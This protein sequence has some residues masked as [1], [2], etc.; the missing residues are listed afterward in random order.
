VN[1]V[2]TGFSG[3][4]KTAVGK[5]LAAA[6]GRSFIDVNVI[7]EEREGDRIA[8]IRQIHGAAHVGDLER[9]VIA[10]V[11]EH[12]NLVVAVGT[13]VLADETNYQNIRR[14]PSVIVCLTA[15]PA[16]VILRSV[17]GDHGYVMLKS[18]NAIG[19]IRRLI[20]EQ[21]PHYRKADYLLDTSELTPEQAAEKIRE[22]IAK[23]KDEKPEIKGQR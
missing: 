17:A 4:G 2:L 9:T 1:I 14:L 20:K 7:I 12:D 3:T 6:L 19:M 5:I 22:T 11:S 18:A 13:N 23:I 16:R 10:E 8:R 21:I 15:E